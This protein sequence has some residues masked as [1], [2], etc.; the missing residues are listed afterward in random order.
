MELPTGPA[1]TPYFGASIFQEA[2]RCPAWASTKLMGNRPPPD[3]DRLTPPKLDRGGW[4]A[5][6]KLLGL[7]ADLAP[8]STWSAGTHPV[9]DLAQLAHDRL[10]DVPDPVQEFAAGLVEALLDA[11]SSTGVP[12]DFHPAFISR[13]FRGGQIHRGGGFIFTGNDAAQIWRLRFAAGPREATEAQGWALTAAFAIC[14]QFPTALRIEVYELN[15][16]T[17]E[18]KQVADWPRDAVEEQFHRD[19]EEALRQLAHDTRVQPGGYCAS[20][21]FIASCPGVTVADF[22]PGVPATTA[23]QKVTASELKDYDTCPARYELL[24]T[25]GLPRVPAESTDAMTR[26]SAIDA[27]LTLNHTTGRACDHD[28][29]DNLAHATPDAESIG[30]H[31]LSVCF[32]GD[33]DATDVLSQ[34]THVLV[35]RK[36]R[37]M[38]VARPDAEYQRGGRTVWR[39]TKTTS[40]GRSWDAMSLV[41]A[42]ITAALYLLMLTT[43]EGVNADALEWE[44]L[45]PL[46]A[47]VTILAADDDELV[48]TA[49]RTV[50]A[51]I[52]DL[53]SDDT[54]S[55]RPGPRC[56]KC[57]A[58]KWCPDAE[59][60]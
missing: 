60:P 14:E 31:H 55:P 52:A 6:S 19:T 7:L 4:L 44:L 29:V 47:E 1:S 40:A 48:E 27:W 39:E 23:I 28:D 59:Q 53:R 2:S 45:S 11:Q 26:G 51:A 50:S 18:I 33:D 36:S 5:T 38:L 56:E 58:A 22:L 41:Q 57:S 54:R 20:C 34:Q 42:D 46:G 15:A 13:A 43:L 32:L 25:Q 9:E 30:H 10:A 37:V 49:R 35:D 3:P 24:V 12:M 8:T 16:T 21:K 17:A